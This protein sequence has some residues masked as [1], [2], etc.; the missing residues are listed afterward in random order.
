MG[1]LSPLTA[2]LD[3]TLPVALC[4]GGSLGSV[5]LCCRTLP[6]VT[7]S[8]TEL[9]LPHPPYQ[10][11]RSTSACRSKGRLISPSRV[12]RCSRFFS[13]PQRIHSGGG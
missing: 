11:Q 5:D 9:V 10:V 6:Y 7:L 12:D 4:N 2:L 8:E 1:T 13:G 3:D